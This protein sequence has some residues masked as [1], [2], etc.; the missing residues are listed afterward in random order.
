MTRG[1]SPVGSELR[2]PLT[3]I[4]GVAE[5]L[6]DGTTLTEAERRELV[7]IIGE[8]ASRLNALSK[9]TLALAQLERAEG[10]AQS[11]QMEAVNCQAQVETAMRLVRLK[12]NAQD[13]RIECAIDGGADD[14]QL[15][16]RGD[17]QLLQEVLVNLI[18][19]AL[20]YS[21]SDRI[22]IR[23]EG[24]PKDVCLTVTDFGIGIPAEHLPRLFER[25]YRV[26]KARSRSLGG[27]GLGLAIVKHIVRLHGGT[28]SVESN[29]GRRTTFGFVIP[30]SARAAVAPKREKGISSCR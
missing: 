19:N 28:V 16:I 14:A 30:K 24:H 18:E 1:Q 6:G 4:L 26:D 12:A 22:L 7:S 25:F 10:S 13:V 29:P 20:R 21:G 3:S 15:T 23:A 11:M 27:T 8:Q 2:T 5:M 17:A 9:D